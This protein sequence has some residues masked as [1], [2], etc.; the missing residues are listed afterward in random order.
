MPKSLSP[1]GYHCYHLSRNLNLKKRDIL[2]HLLFLIKGSVWRYFLAFILVYILAFS[3]FELASLMSINHWSV[4]LF[5]S[6][7]QGI[8]T[9]SILRLHA[10]PFLF[11]LILLVLFLSIIPSIKGCRLPGGIK[12]VQHSEHPFSHF[13]SVGLPTLILILFFFFVG[14]VYPAYVIIKSAVP[15]FP[16]L[17]K[18]FWMLK[19]LLS[20]LLFAFAASLLSY[21]IASLLPPLTKTGRLKIALFIVFI[22]V[23]IGMLPLSLFVF[24]LFQIPYIS[25]L[26]DTPLPLLTTLTMWSLPFVLILQF[27]INSFSEGEST[28]SARLLLPFSKSKAT[29]LLWSFKFRA[30]FS[31]FFFVFALTYFDLTASAIL[32]PAS[33]TTVTARFYNLM[34]Y[35][36]S[37]KLSATVCLSFIVPILLFSVIGLGL[38]LLIKRWN[39]L[40]KSG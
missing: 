7:S 40:S 33:M 38:K 28:H 6:Y 23:L 35:G 22:P 36:E 29:E 34:H 11:Q 20:S 24:S 9:L 39:A 26:S 16:I 17:L 4:S 30:A 27:I 18:E 10:F 2:T 14:V 15:G 19:E 13:K 37:E 3:E 12:D 31:I 1:E 21:I 25:S 5:D 8:S 32:A